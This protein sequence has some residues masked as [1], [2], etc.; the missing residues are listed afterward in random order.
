MLKTI[1]QSII[2]FWVCL[3]GFTSIYNSTSA[4]YQYWYW[5]VWPAGEVKVPWHWKNTERALI[6][7]IQT[8]IN[9][10]LW[11]LSL[12]ALVLCLYAWFKMM[13]SSWDSKQY[14]AW[15]SILKNAAIWLAIIGLSRMIVSLIFWFINGAADT[16]LNGW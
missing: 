7:T 4:Q 11:M 6:D 8:A 5:E 15:F 2:V 14:G 16:T 9:R 10:V 13:T 1:K 12:I 3:L